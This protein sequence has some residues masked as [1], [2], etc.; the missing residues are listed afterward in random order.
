M[1]VQLL[2]Q[3]TCANAR[4]PTSLTSD[5]VVMSELKARSIDPLA[6]I[7]RNYLRY[8]SLAFALAGFVAGLIAAFHWWGSTKVKVRDPFLPTGSPEDQEKEKEN[9]KKF[10]R[11]TGIRGDIAAWFIRIEVANVM[12]SDW[13]RKAAAWTA[14]SVLLNAISSILGAWP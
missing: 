4:T 14:L 5:L 1:P 11:Q 3:E 8:A 13:N 2:R 6:T 9:R 10:E 7:G 12:A